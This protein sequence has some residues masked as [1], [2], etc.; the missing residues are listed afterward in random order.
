MA[1]N[2]PLWGPE[3][4]TLRRGIFTL[5]YYLPFLPASAIIRRVADV[6]GSGPNPG[7]TTY[8]RLTPPGDDCQPD[9]SPPLATKRQ[10]RTPNGLLLL[11]AL[12]PRAARRTHPLGP[13]QSG[14]GS[15]PTGGARAGVDGEP[16]TPARPSCPVPG[17]SGAP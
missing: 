15:V 8:F 3:R 2:E 5:L 1:A 13:D 10:T 6:L 14:S 11:S 7:R 12:T 17:A 16:I 9:A 4:T